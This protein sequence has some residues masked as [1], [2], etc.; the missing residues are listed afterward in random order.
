MEAFFVIASWLSDLMPMKRF[1]DIIASAVAG[2]YT[3]LH[4]TGNLPVVYRKEG[5][6][7]FDRSS[8]WHPREIDGLVAGILSHRQAQMLRKRWSVDLALTV[9][10]TRLRINV[11]S[12]VRGL[13]LAIRLL[14]EAVF[15]LSALNLHPSLGQ[16][17]DLKSGLVLICGPT[18][19]GKSTTIAA[20]VEELN[21]TRPAHIITLEEPVEYRFQGKMAF[22]EQ[23]EVGIHVPSFKQGLLDA[24]RENPDVI[25]VGEL[26]EADAIRLALSAAESG[27]LVLATLHANDVEDAVYR[28]TASTGGE[29]QTAIRYQLA[30]TISWVIVQQF[31]RLERVGFRVPALSVMKGTNSIRSIIRENRFAQLEMAI[32]TGKS[33]GMFSLERYISEYLNSR[34]TVLHPFRP[35]RRTDPE[36]PEHRSSL[37]DPDAIQDVVYMTLAGEEAGGDRFKKPPSQ[38]PA[39]HQLEIDEEIDLEYLI[40]QIERFPGSREEPK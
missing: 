12:T 30:S 35:S 13:S 3:D 8:P 2:G 14:P 27:H 34:E 5:V 1:E 15:T 21:R 31:I 9:D 33:E 7:N 22:I 28:I 26:R 36:E 16:I 29:G 23:R 18:G 25:V 20:L 38:A 19:S 4:I 17:Q 37:I 24:L 6:I 11:F 40:S 39:G 32:H 10:R